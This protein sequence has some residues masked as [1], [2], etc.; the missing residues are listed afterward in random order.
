[1]SEC[2]VCIGGREP[3][4]TCEVFEQTIVKKSRKL[5]KCCECGRE[6]PVGSSYESTFTVYEGDAVRLKTCIACA[7][8]RDTFNCDGGVL[9]NGQLWEEIVQAD[10][11]GNLNTGCIAKLKTVEAKQYLTERWQKWKG[12]R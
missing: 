12:L 5:H 2:N 1:M 3:D 8:I 11:F 10:F 4:G 9:I 6:I 7:D